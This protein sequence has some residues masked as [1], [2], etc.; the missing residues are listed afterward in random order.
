MDIF[1]QTRI[2]HVRPMIT[3]ICL[4]G[5]NI[6]QVEGILEFSV[7]SNLRSLASKRHQKGLRDLSG[8]VMVIWMVPEYARIY[9][10]LA[11]LY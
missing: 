1:A 3:M 7:R 9:L 4:V 2:G 10:S 8:D 6:L 11:T 5:F